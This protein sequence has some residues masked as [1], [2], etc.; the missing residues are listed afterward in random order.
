MIMKSQYHAI[1]T[2]HAYGKLAKID[3]EI[4]FCPPYIFQFKKR[5]TPHLH[6]LEG[7][8]FSDAHHH[9]LADHFKNFNL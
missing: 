1:K 6:F 7:L 8:F 4:E 2:P 5:E 9:F 3:M